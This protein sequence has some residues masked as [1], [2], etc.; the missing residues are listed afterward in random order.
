[1]KHLKKIITHLFHTSKRADHS[2]HGC[3]FT[4][5]LHACSN[6][7]EPLELPA[8]SS[9]LALSV[10]FF[11]AF[12]SHLSDHKLAQNRPKPTPRKVAFPRRDVAEAQG[13]TGKVL[14]ICSEER[15][16]KI[17]KVERPVASWI[18]SY[19]TQS[20]LYSFVRGY[21]LCD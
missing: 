21:F 7:L 15:C 6:R 10:L 11:Q 16:F 2:S 19:G 17:V 9:R 5:K 20:L 14:E 1:M 18:F 8:Q 4:T 13:E 12:L 3:Q